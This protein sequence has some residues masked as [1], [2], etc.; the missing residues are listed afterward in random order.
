MKHTSLTVVLLA[1][2]A[3][4]C[5]E[6]KGRVALTAS[7]L[8]GST[9]GAGPVAPTAGNLGRSSAVAPAAGL[10]ATSPDQA[11]IT[12]TGI[13]F[14]KEDGTGSSATL[15]DCVVHYVRAVP[16]LTKM[17]DCPFTIDPGTYV[18]IEVDIANSFDVLIDDQVNNIYTDAASSTKLSSTRPAG[19]ATMVNYS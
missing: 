14:V 4:G 16:S 12:I 19:G 3:S 5:T 8:H 17:L 2:A 15:T 1:L 10:W 11:H 6:P 13:A 7:V 9:P 18:A